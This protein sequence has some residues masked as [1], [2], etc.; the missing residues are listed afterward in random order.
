MLFPISTALSAIP[1][2]AS[3]FSSLNPSDWIQLFGII[4]SLVASLIAIALS[5]LT[6][7]QNNKMVE[8][9][10]RPN[11]QIYP[12]YA[13]SI[14]YIIIKNFGTSTAIIDSVECDHIFTNSESF[15]DPSETSFSKLSGA[16]FCPGYSLKCPLIS[17]AVSNETFNFH[18]TYHS[19]SKK[20]SDIFSFNPYTNAPFADTHPS[21]HTTEE[22][23]KNISHDLHNIFK[24]KL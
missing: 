6:L 23:L 15:G 19:T 18:V 9:S 20:Y 5:V 2:I 12:V 22:Y 4:V 24:T 3:F 14:L 16:I 21:A 17:H 10:T 11:I 1:Q 8:E 13:D 7:R